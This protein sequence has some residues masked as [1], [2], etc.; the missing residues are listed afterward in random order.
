MHTP[1]GA[2]STENRDAIVFIMNFALPVSF[3]YL[4]FRIHFISFLSDF[5][6]SFL[7]RENLAYFYSF[8]EPFTSQLNSSFRDYSAPI[9]RAYKH[10]PRWLR[11]VRELILGAIHT[12]K[13]FHA[14]ALCCITTGLTELKS[15]KDIEAAYLASAPFLQLKMCVTHLKRKTHSESAG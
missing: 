4:L 13:L 8:M 3:K 10:K 2:H 11:E 7:F 15:V 12:Q 1:L 5:F 6:L 14:I 9:P